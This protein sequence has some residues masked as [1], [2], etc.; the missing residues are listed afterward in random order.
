[1]S[2]AF[3]KRLTDDRG[4]V[5]IEFAIVAPV[6]VFMMAGVVDMSNAFGRKLVL[7][8]GTQRAIEKIMQTTE[9]DTVEGT[10]KTEVICQVN[11]LNANGTCKSTPITTSNVTVTYRLECKAAGGGITTQTST[12][13][14]AFDA[15]TCTAGSTEAR[16]ISVAVTDKYAPLFP[17][18]FG[19]LNA[20]GTYHVSAT[21]GMRTQ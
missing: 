18:N 1:M 5:L 9:M 8:Q 4:A 17:F 3:F 6:L 2:R 16:Y 14:D 19:S 21:A 20:D 12:D 7:E 15:L 10:L 11:G 13:A